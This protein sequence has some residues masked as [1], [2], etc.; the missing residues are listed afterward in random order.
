MYTSPCPG[1]MHLEH[2]H[3]AVSHS[4]NN[5]H[6]GVW[7]GTGWQYEVKGLSVHRVPPQS[8]GL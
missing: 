1:E 3:L 2:L 5:K 7:L 6:K 8:V 4:L